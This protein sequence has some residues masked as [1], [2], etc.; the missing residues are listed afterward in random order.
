MKSSSR[1]ARKVLN[2]SCRVSLLLVT[3]ANCLAADDAASIARLHYEALL[4]RGLITGAAFASIDHGRVIDTEFIGK[5]HAD[6]LWRAASTSKAFTALA[7][8][9]LARRGQIALDGDVNTYLK[10]FKVPPFRG[11]PITVRELLDHMSGLD[12]P[13]VGTGYLDPAGP[14]PKLPEVMRQYLP[15]SDYLPG[16]V[17]LYSNFGYGI[18]GALIEDVTNVPYDQYMRVEVLQPL[19]M[20]DSTFEQPLPEQLRQRVVPSIERTIFGKIRTSELLYHRA[21]AAGGLTTSFQDLI[22]FAQFI[23]NGVPVGGVPVLRAEEPL[24]VGVKWEQR[25]WYA[26][27][28]LGGYHTVLLWFPDHDCALVTVAAGVSEMATWGMVPEVVHCWFG[29]G[30]APRTSEQIVPNPHPAEYSRKVAGIYRPVRYPHFDIAK[31]FAVTM[32]Q[33]VK[34]EADG[35]ITYNGQ[36]WLPMAPLRFREVS[37]PQE[38]TF[39]TDSQGRVR[40]VDNS[41]ERIAWYQSGRAAI[42]LY[43]GFIV[44]CVIALIVQR[45]RASMRALGVTAGLILAHSVA[46]LSAALAADPQRLILGLPWYLSCALAI[47]TIV[48]FAWIYLVAVTAR[49]AFNGAWPTS[50][51]A[52]S[53]AGVLAFAFYIPFEFYWR[54]MLWPF[55]SIRFG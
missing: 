44:L 11:K 36:R 14:Q 4:R 7:V 50:A 9:Q 54:I 12:D 22:Q 40:F 46:W 19:G 34:S 21:T 28:D 45:N 38:L 39:Q 13:F 29:D 17:R 1:A 55:A 25:Y 16:Q 18:L 3:L 33:V 20:R 53:T 6:S 10:S 47:G 35:S 2:C 32:D 8:M 42:A 26:G 31:T 37:G 27:G 30:K 48:P 5:M 52:M 41:A 23:Q 43:F 24:G 15:R 51:L 49:A